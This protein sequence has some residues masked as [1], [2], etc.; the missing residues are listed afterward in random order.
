MTTRLDELAITRE[1]ALA[2]LFAAR[3]SQERVT[4]AGVVL[5]VPAREVLEVEATTRGIEILDHNRMRFVAVPADRPDAEGKTGLCRLFDIEHERS[6]APPRYV[7]AVV[8]P[9]AQATPVELPSPARRSEPPVKRRS[10]L[11]ALVLS[12][13]GATGPDPEVD[14]PV[15]RHLIGLPDELVDRYQAAEAADRAELA[16]LNERLRTVLDDGYSTDPDLVLTSGEGAGNPGARRH[17]AQVQA[18]EASG[19]VDAL[20]ALTGPDRVRRIAVEERMLK[21][22]I[23]VVRNRIRQRSQAHARLQRAALDVAV[24]EVADAHRPAFD[25]AARYLADVGAVLE[26]RDAVVGVRPLQSL[27]GERALLA[28]AEAA[29]D[30]PLGRLRV[31]RDQAVAE[32]SARC[33]GT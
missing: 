13:I 25:A 4:A 16:R 22:Q 28:G 10:R 29:I 17:T 31:E 19:D 18:A 9:P 2:R 7:D 15:S 30:E 11:V 24:V 32:L 27:I 14:E 8:A 26:Q 12:A 21:R 23:G 20:L 5:G 1:V 6:L 3:S 33:G